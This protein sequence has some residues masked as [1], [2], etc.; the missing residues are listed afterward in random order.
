MKSLLERALARPFYS[1]ALVIAAI[2]VVA[3]LWWLLCPAAS[4]VTTTK[5]TIS[6][7]VAQS[8][9]QQSDSESAAAT[10]PPAITAATN[11]VAVAPVAAANTALPTDPALAEEELDRLKDE[12]TRLN[13]RKA[14]LTQQLEI[15]NKLLTMKEQQLKTLETPNH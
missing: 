11:P 1:T 4:R 8:A 5:T 9:A 10:A 6:T 14:Q 3:L 15:S 13:D 2:A 7:S 12:H